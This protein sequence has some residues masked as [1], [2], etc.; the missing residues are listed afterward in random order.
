MK[1]LLALV[2]PTAVGKTAAAIELAKRLDGEIVTADSVQVYIGMDVGSA[3]PDIRERSMAKHHMIDLVEPDFPY[4]V[5]L[6]KEAATAV[7]EDIHSRGKLPILA[8]G[9][10]LYV[11]SLLYP[12][13]FTDASCDEAYREELKCIAQEQGAEALHAR[14]AL[15][16]EEA[17]ANIHPN[18]Q[19]RVIRALEVYHMT[20]RPFS[21]FQTGYKEQPPPYN[22]TLVGLTMPRSELYERIDRR[23]DAM[24][25]R[26]FLDEVATLLSKYPKNCRAFNSLGYKQLIAY[27]E[28]EYS[29]QDALSL[30]KRDTRRFAK[31]QLTWFNRD[32]RIR[33]YSIFDYSR[34]EDLIMDIIHKE[35]IES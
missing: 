27:M 30:I 6:Y 9:T 10:G 1:P 20:G 31:R 28:G 22:L 4:S 17:A 5:A 14:L 25:E 19:K 7:I 32:K 23:V 13:D 11:N 3:K 29:L 15:V 34:I 8:G 24:M 2:G 26:H 35:E 33:W 12:M 16:D 21:T 18:N